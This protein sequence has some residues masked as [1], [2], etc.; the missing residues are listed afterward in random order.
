MIWGSGTQAFAWLQWFRRRWGGNAGA[1][2]LAH[3]LIHDNGSGNRDVERADAA[4]HRDA[5]E[6][7]TGA[8]DKFVEAGAFG[9][10]DKAGV[11]LEVEI[12]VV[13]GAA[14][15]KADDPNVVFLE[16][17]ERAGD[18]ND[19]SDADMFAGAGAGFGGGA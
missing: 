17:F 9:A 8:F 13:G 11:L 18:V 4:G 2:A 14:L 12:G 6:V 19:L 3:G 5:Q 7:V 15:V 1:A 16:R 10:E